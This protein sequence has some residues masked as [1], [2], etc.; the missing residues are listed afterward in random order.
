MKWIVIFFLANGLEHVHGEVEIC[1]YAKI[2]EQVEIFRKETK[3]D[4][5]GWGCYDEKTFIIRQ[6]ARESLGIDV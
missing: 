4:V 6:K 2:D 5:E 1:D 3:K